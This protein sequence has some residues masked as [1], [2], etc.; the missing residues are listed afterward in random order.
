MKRNN[1]KLLV[2]ER[3][4]FTRK[5]LA[6]ILGLHFQLIFA[7]DGLELLEQARLGRPDLIIL[8]ALLPLRDGFQV[9][10]ALKGRPNY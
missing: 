8:E 5:Q 10:R 4:P 3:D 9:C 7:E 1:P 6:A 2:G